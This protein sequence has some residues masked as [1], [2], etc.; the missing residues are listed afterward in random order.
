MFIPTAETFLSLNCFENEKTFFGIK[1]VGRL[2]FVSFVRFSLNLHENK[3]TIAREART[4]WHQR[5][6]K[7]NVELEV[8]WLCSTHVNFCL[9]VNNLVD[10]VFA[11]CYACL[12][13]DILSKDR[14]EMIDLLFVLGL[15]LNF[16][17]KNKMLITG[18]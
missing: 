16:S 13:K 17:C 8:T 12:K 7:A 3:T 5:V 10:R 2:T 18:N 6:K 11:L 4:T 9:S 1:C 15:V 14:L